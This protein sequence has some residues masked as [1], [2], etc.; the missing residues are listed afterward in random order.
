[1]YRS[2]PLPLSIWIVNPFDDIPGEGLPPLRYWSLARVLAARGHDLV[3]VARSTS[4]LEALAKEEVIHCAS[5]CV[6]TSAMGFE[7]WRFTG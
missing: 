1:M 7:G 5:H 6:C 3:L 2:E 4:K